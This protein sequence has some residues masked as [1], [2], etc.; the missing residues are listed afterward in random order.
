MT[1]IVIKMPSQYFPYVY[2]LFSL[3]VCGPQTA[4]V[5]ATGLA[6][7]HLYDLLGGLYPSSGIKRNL[8]STPDWVKRMF[9][10]QSVI[11]RPYG[12]V[13]M[14]TSRTGATG[15]AAWGLD[16][17]WKRFGEGRR[18]GGEGESSL[19]SQRP[20]GWV[21]AVIGLAAYIIICGLLGFFFFLNGV[22]DGWASVISN[23]KSS[24]TVAPESREPVAIL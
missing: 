3:I 11:E 7:A 12:S 21:L 14:P 2:L 17:S 6:A 19:P 5:Q 1:F 22:P 10:T 18:L 23:G 9:G 24:S 8:I 13:F 16:L 20:K 4:I 15:E